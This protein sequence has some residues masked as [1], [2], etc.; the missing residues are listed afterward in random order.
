[1]RPAC[2]PEDLLGL[3]HTLEAEDAAGFLLSGGSD[4]SGKVPVDRFS[5]AIRRIKDGTGLVVNAHVGLMPRVGLEAL[6]SAGVDAFSVDIYGADRVIR[7]TLGLAATSDDF[8]R[9]MTD[10]KEIGAPVI[11]PHVCIGLEPGNIS[12]ELDA[13][14]R[15]GP[16]RPEKLIL[17]AFTPTEGTPYEGRPSPPSKAILDVVRFAREELPKTR[18]FLGCMRPRKDRGYEVDAVAAGIDG[19][20]MPSGETLRHLQ[21]AGVKVRDQRICCALG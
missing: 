11:A 1:M 21:K 3:A 10:L 6:V 18:I 15:L 9:V 20:V 4:S 13:V 14:S 5:G 2:S 16:A 7:E 17:I 12:S 8:F 19:I